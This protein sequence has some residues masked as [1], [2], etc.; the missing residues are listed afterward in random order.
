MNRF[1]LGKKHRWLVLALV[2]SALFLIVVDMT[3]LYTALPR[4]TAALEA[5]AVE[6]LWI[7]NTYGLVVAGLLPGTGTLG[8]RLGPKPL[9][10]LGLIVFGLASLLAAFAPSPAL[11]IGA[12]AC[13]AVGAALM[14]PATLSI[15]RHTFTDERERALAIGVWSA[16]AS[17]G[18]MLGPVLGGLLLEVFWWGSVFLINVPIV[19]LVLLPALA[20]VPRVAPCRERP[21]DGVGS[22][23]ILI[24]L[25]ALTYALK[26]ASRPVPSG[27]AALVALAIGGLAGVVF[28]RRQARQTSPLIDFGLFRQNAFAGGVLGAIVASIALIGAEYLFVQHVQLVGGRSP[29]EAALLLLPLPLASLIA[30]PVAGLGVTRWGSERVLIVALALCALGSAGLGLLH[31]RAEGGT[32]VSLSLLG[33]GFG[34]AATGAS[35]AILTNAPPSR[36]GMAASIEEV[37]YEL[38]GALGVALLGCLLSVLYAAALVLPPE[39]PVVARESLD[40]ALRV[41]AGLPDGDALAEAARLAF[42]RAFSIVMLSATALLGGTVL[43][44]THWALRK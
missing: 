38:G 33:L 39:V 7:V 2:S 6:S 36:A 27:T 35:S 11:L 3:V 1:L 25:V 14:M 22:G 30:G 40:D 44:L 34:A 15:I 10:L 16:V 28:V 41:A 9:F 26:E 8:D 21:W 24:T 12:R 32:L 31:G 19:L 5:S 4:L 23:L 17:G 13:L 37:S 20:L 43:V 42:D 18:A 29:L